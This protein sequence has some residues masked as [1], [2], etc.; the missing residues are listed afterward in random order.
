MRGNRVAG[1]VVVMAALHVIVLSIVPSIARRDG[2]R[3]REDQ[4]G[5]SDLDSGPGYDIFLEA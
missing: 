2:Q 3:K 1:F 5:R 4:G